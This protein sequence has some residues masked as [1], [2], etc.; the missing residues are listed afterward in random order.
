MTSIAE[1]LPRR[2]WGRAPAAVAFAV[3][4]ALLALL[5]GSPD[6]GAAAPLSEPD[7]TSGE[8]V[9]GE[10]IV[11]FRDEASGDDR[12]TAREAADASLERPLAVEDVQL[13][14]LDPGTS[15]DEGVARL[16]RDPNVLYAEPNLVRRSDAT[17]N[18]SFLRA[19]WGLDNTAQDVRGFTGTADADV[20]GPEAWD[21]ETGDSSV[22]VAVVDTGVDYT[23]PDLDGNIRSNPDE[24][25]GNGIDDDLNTKIDD[26]RGWD[27]VGEPVPGGGPRTEDNDPQ[28]P[29]GHGT[30]VA[31]TVGAEGNNGTGVTG[32][33][34]DVSLMPLRVLDE[35]GSGTVADVVDGYAYAARE[36][37]DVINASLGGSGRSRTEADFFNT[38]PAVVF[39]TAAGNEGTDNDEEPRFPC[40]Q[41]QE[42][43]ICV[44]ASGQSDQLPSFSNRGRD[45]VDLAAPG[46]NILSTY[47]VA[48]TGAGFAPYAFLD[49]TSM[50]TP[51]VAGAAALVKARFP[52]ASVLEVRNRLLAT[53]DA[54]PAFDCRT[55]TGGRL[56]VFRA[57]SASA[58]GPVS[59]ASCVPDPASTPT[60]TPAPASTSDSR[61][62]GGG[63]S[64]GSGDG[65]SGS[66]SD[67]VLEPA[68]PALPTPAFTPRP[69]PRSR[70][71]RLAGR[72]RTACVRRERALARCAKL[73][74]TKR[75]ACVRRAGRASR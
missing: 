15:V 29:E 40:N 24:V 51:H 21:L 19:L 5:A 8:V 36:G 64:G 61:P 54:K 56:S 48:L 34:Q 14:E 50:A 11:R 75:S 6:E 22:V 9:P 72:K 62:Q 66:G 46:E 55:F 58:S 43:V 38:N 67:P 44:A 49:G 53:V 1:L 4:I 32:V 23:H 35:S 33:N 37:A 63:D 70:C 20:D 27:F 30:H 71:T 68:P 45:N 73:A 17:T 42:N 69:M 3:A 28:D 18:D 2:I 26:V 65:D 16:E 47:P 52:S 39:V 74:R 25:A 31:G 60:P 57:L 59:Q 41:P 10:V 7:A 12:R 13:L